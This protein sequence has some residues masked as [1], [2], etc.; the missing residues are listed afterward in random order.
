MAN[1]V[2]LAPP[3]TYAWKAAEDDVLEAILRLTYVPVYLDPQDVRTT[4]ARPDYP[5]YSLRTRYA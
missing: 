2:R 1:P 3:R 4:M 5:F